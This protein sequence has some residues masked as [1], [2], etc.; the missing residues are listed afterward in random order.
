MS[1]VTAET[2]VP[3]RK[4]SASAIPPM[5]TNTG[6]PISAAKRIS[7]TIGSASEWPAAGTRPSANARPIAANATRRPPQR[8]EAPHARRSARSANAIGITHS[9]SH[10]GTPIASRRPAS[11][12]A[13]TTPYAEYAR[14]P[15][16]AAAT[17]DDT[18]RARSRTRV[19]A[20]ASA[21]DRVRWWRSRA[22]SRPPSSA[23]HRVSWARY[24][25]DP[26]KPRWPNGRP[27]AS[28]SGTT[29]DSRNANT[30]TPPSRRCSHESGP[31]SLGLA[32][33]V[34][35][36]Q[37]RRRLLLLL[38]G[39]RHVRG[40]HRERR[41]CPRGVPVEVQRARVA[42]PLDAD[43]EPLDDLRQSRNL[44][45]DLVEVALGL[46]LGAPLPRLGVDDECPA[47]RRRQRPQRIEAGRDHGAAEVERPVR[48]ELCRGV[49]IGRAHVCTP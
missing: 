32:T 42:G 6:A 26:G 43:R 47:G 24:S 13:I 37:T 31:P 40:P 46:V 29:I 22:A 23:S 17:A 2:G 20:I 30:S 1:A 14:T 28:T 41:R 49:Q 21:V 34:C 3:S 7:A 11:R 18:T 44:H 35:I 9:E 19:L 25:C 38:G 48:A 15:H 10:T 8:S 33:S 36:R 12:S 4:N 45:R 27:I 16:T 39:L 5:A